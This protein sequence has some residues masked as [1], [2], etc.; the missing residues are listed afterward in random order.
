MFV[1][2][3]DSLKGLYTEKIILC[4]SKLLLPLLV[5]VIS[6]MLRSLYSYAWGL[7]DKLKDIPGAFFM[8]T[9][10]T[11]VIN[12]VIDSYPGYSLYM[13]WKHQYTTF[14]LSL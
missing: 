7:Y 10:Y 12:K 3:F 2:R 14:Y 6:G 9:Q 4:A 13:I 1:A 5:R 8:R 11:L